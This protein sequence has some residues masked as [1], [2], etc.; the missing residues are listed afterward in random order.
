LYAKCKPPIYLA[1]PENLADKLQT[2]IEDEVLRNKLSEDG[3]EYV[4][5][6]HDPRKVVDK[7]TEMYFHN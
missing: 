3:R 6:I 2:L 4:Q 7:L 1:T 5:K